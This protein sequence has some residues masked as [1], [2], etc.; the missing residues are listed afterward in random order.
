VLDPT[1]NRIFLQ[2]VTPNPG[3]SAQDVFGARIPGRSGETIAGLGDM[4]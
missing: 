2:A 4:A 1:T 3:V